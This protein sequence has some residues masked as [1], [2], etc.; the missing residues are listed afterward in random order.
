MPKKRKKIY[1]DVPYFLRNAAKTIGAMWDNDEKKW[2]IY[3]TFDVEGL[4]RLLESAK[5]NTSITSQTTYPTLPYPKKNIEKKI[6]DSNDVLCKFKI[7][8]NDAGLEVDMPIMD[9]A[10]HRVRVQGDRGAQKSGAYIGHNN[11]TPAG[12][13]QNFKS[14]FSTNW[15]YESDNSLVNSQSNNTLLQSGNEQTALSEGVQAP[16][17]TKNIKQNSNFIK[18]QQKRDL[19]LIKEH[20][21]AADILKDEFLRSYTAE[22]NHPYLVKKMIHSNYGLRLDI[23]GNLLMPLF[24]ASGKFWSVQRIFKNGDKMIGALLSQ[25]QKQNNEKIYAKKR[26]N[27]Y[28]V[29][30]GIAYDS[31]TVTLNNQILSNVGKVF[32]CEGFATA[33]SVHEASGV[34]TVVGVDVGNLEY[35]VRGLQDKFPHLRIII[36]ADNDLK[37]EK[38]GRVNIGKEKALYI[39][40]NYKNISI[41]MPVFNTIEVDSMCSDFNDLHKSRG[42]AEVRKQLKEII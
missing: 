27:F 18:K 8:L 2:F 31:K 3:D 33:V 39:K 24:D 5:T 28:I 9:G 20:T 1:V 41:C 35:V 26:G 16:Y 21:K 22:N 6:F 7:A 14:G 10:I 4:M 23:Y 11:E 34:P 12:F 29:T 13:I 38:E 42:L 30:D 36:A 15:K 17:S 32:L 19:E 25:A 40:N 37:N